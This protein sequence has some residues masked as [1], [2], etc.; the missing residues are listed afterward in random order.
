MLKPAPKPHPGGF[1]LIELAVALVIFA[2]LALLG[3][4]SFQKWIKEGQI[5]TT[6]ES[7]KSGLS[8]A[9]QLAIKTNSP[10]K[11]TLNPVAGTRWN[12]T[13]PSNVVLAQAPIEGGGAI[14]VSPATASITFNSLGQ[15][16]PAGGTLCSGAASSL[17][18]DA[19]K[20]TGSCR[21]LA[22]GAGGSI[23]T[24][25]VTNTTDSSLRKLDITTSSGGEIRTCDPDTSLPAGDPRKC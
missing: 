6:A 19:T 16:K 17:L 25:E 21:G 4:P 14:A 15:I 24:I 7:I 12:V 1:T 2:V 9:R 22:L 13:N 8:Q 10:M 11:F 18:E 3:I 23:T 5:R 20:H